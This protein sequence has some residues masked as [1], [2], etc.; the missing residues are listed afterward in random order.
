MNA[1]ENL[2]VS[3]NKTCAQRA[4]ENQDKHMRL[5]A[6]IRNKVAGGNTK[7]QWLLED[8]SEVDQETSYLTLYINAIEKDLKKRAGYDRETGDLEDRRNYDESE[9][10]MMGENPSANEGSGNGEARVLRIKLETYEE[11]SRLRMI[12]YQYPD[13]LELVEPLVVQPKDDPWVIENQPERAALTWEEDQFYDKPV[14]ALLATLAQLKLRVLEMETDQLNMMSMNLGCDLTAYS[15]P[16][17]F[18][19]PE[20]EVVVAGMKFETK[21]FQAK[22]APLADSGETTSLIMIRGGDTLIVRQK[23]TKVEDEK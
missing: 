23:M 9:E 19:I 7:H 20:S 13:L 16:L 6:R 22:D 8:L 5:R 17:E 18:D 12:D 2:S 21:V 15:Y 11:K 10:L 4:S 1:F 3:L 14:V